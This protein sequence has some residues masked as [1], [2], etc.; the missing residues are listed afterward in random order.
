MY[1]FFALKPY[2]AFPLV[3]YQL[4]WDLGEH[5]MGLTYFKYSI[6]GGYGVQGL[7]PPEAFDLSSV[8]FASA[9]KTFEVLLPLFDDNFLRFTLVAHSRC[10]VF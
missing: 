2:P 3:L 4:H 1:I 6:M 5:K 7:A 9:R 10:S 8:D